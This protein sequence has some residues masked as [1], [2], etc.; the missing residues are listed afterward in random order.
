LELE[1]QQSLSLAAQTERG[2]RIAQLTDELALK[3]ALLEQAEANA[4]EAARRAEPELSDHADD[5]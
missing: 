5:R 1:R 3:S 4:V 2:H